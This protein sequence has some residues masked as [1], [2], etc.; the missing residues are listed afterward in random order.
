M[1]KVEF[2]TVVAVDSSTVPVAVGYELSKNSSGVN[3]SY[4]NFGTVDCNITFDDEV[5]ELR[6]YNIKLNKEGIVIRYY[7][8]VWMEEYRDYM[9]EFIEVFYRVGDF[10]YICLINYIDIDNIKK[11]LN[12]SELEKQLSMDEIAE[13][14]NSGNKEKV[15][16]YLK[17]LK[18]CL[19]CEY[20]KQQLSYK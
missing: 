14:I 2:Q 19:I 15:E 3:V 6:H 7:K 8:D 18:F 17:L 9:D 11:Y 4:G 12:D 1:E 16:K 10:I 13:A 20:S 5:D